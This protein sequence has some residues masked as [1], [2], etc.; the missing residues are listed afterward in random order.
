MKRIKNETSNEDMTIIYRVAEIYGFQV[1]FDPDL[2]KLTI[3]SRDSQEYF[4]WS[5]KQPFEDFFNDLKIFFMN[6]GVEMYR[7][8]ILNCPPGAPRIESWNTE[9]SLTEE[10]MN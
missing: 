9:H 10:F 7:Q 5:S 4:Y 1:S 2:N 6:E 3:L 8:R